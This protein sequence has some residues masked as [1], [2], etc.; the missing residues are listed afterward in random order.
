MDERL[1]A[2]GVV[3]VMPGCLSSKYLFYDPDLSALSL[4]TYTALRWGFS[5]SHL[6]ELKAL[7]ILSFYERITFVTNL[8]EREP[9]VYQFWCKTGSWHHSFSDSSRILFTKLSKT[10]STYVVNCLLA[11]LAD[12]LFESQL[13]KLLNKN[14]FFPRKQTFN[15]ILMRRCENVQRFEVWMKQFNFILTELHILRN[16]RLSFA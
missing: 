9:K 2:V 13:N 8:Y 4:G 6:E 10:E 5:S 7:S 15:S 16:L 3:D 11:A 1:V 12:L 14:C